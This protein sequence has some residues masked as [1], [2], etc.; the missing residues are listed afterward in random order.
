MFKIRSRADRVNKHQWFAWYPV[1]ATQKG[2]NGLTYSW[3]WLKSVGRQY[4]RAA[5]MGQWS[6]E[7]PA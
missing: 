4:I 2:D 5:N 6:Y 7:L 1:L 3:V